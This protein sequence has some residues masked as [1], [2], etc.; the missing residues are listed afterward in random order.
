MI[1]EPRARGFIRHAQGGPAHSQKRSSDGLGATDLE[2]EAKDARDDKL[3]SERQ[4][5]AS[6]LVLH[7]IADEEEGRDLL[8]QQ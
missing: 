4:W 8:P 3:L 7:L 2:A 6:Y 5:I 1:T